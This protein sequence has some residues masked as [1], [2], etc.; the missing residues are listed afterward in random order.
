MNTTTKNLIA[1]DFLAIDHLKGSF[2]GF[3]NQKI[4]E[5]KEIVLNSFLDQKLSP[6]DKPILIH[7]HKHCLKILKKRVLNKLINHN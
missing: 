7:W 5:T 4:R 2:T 1:I 3:T 6:N